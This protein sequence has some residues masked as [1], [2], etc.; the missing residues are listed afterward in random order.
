MPRRVERPAGWWWGIALAAVGSAVLAGCGGSAS[1]ASTVIPS[2][3]PVVTPPAQLDVQRGLAACFVRQEPASTIPGV[4]G[5]R[6]VATQPLPEGLTPTVKNVRFLGAGDSRVLESEICFNADP[7][8]APARVDAQLEL[9]LFTADSE[10]LGLND[11]LQPVRTLPF[12]QV[13]VV[14]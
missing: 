3:P 4:K 6:L 7:N 8:V 5:Y 11:K 9:R 13:V 12:S 1:G 10:K 2:P 14:K